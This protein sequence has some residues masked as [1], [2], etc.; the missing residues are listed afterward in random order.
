VTASKDASVDSV[1]ERL[2]ADLGDESFTVVDH[3]AG[4]LCAV[5]VARP[6]NPRYLVYISTWPPERGTFNY[7][8]ERPS[9]DPE[10][11]YDSDGRVEDVSYE[12]V[13][14]AV[15]RLLRG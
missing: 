13:R 8:C 5:G 2:R 4:D 7:E 3:W 1:L 14:A 12:H 15:G 9:A 10:L 11:P 6:D